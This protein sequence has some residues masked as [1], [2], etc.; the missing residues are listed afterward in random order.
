MYLSQP[1]ISLYVLLHY[2]GELQ[3]WSDGIPDSLRPNNNNFTPPAHM[4][5]IQFLSLRWLD[6]VMVA[7]RPFIA[8][9][10][11]FGGVALSTRT[12]SF[13]IFC[14]RVA[15]IAARET[16]SLMTHMEAQG[17]VKGLTAFERHFLVQSGSILALSSVVQGGQDER[18]RL[19]E[20]IQMLV[21]LPGMKALNL[22]HDMHTVVDKLDRWANQK[23]TKS[24]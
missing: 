12:R 8:S 13:F 17:Q 2:L 24:P 15:S 21:R 18:L 11:R 19:R 20:C 9:L 22:I 10:A 23:G 7:T 16:L 1:N 4:R 6:A 14:A 3:D 5:A